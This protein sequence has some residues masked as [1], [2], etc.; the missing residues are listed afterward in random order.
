MEL[1]ATPCRDIVMISADLRIFFQDVMAVESGR[2]LNESWSPLLMVLMLTSTLVLFDPSV[3]ASSYNLQSRSKR[4]FIDINC[5][6]TYIYGVI[7]QTCPSFFLYL[8]NALAQDNGTQSKALDCAQSMVF[9]DHGFLR[10]INEFNWF[11]VD[12]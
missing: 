6:L 5:K 4:L 11:R 3:A 10:D 8:K 9:T 7:I 2:I 12:K 1:G